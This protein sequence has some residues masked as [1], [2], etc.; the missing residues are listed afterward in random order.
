MEI[1]LKYHNFKIFF[2]KNIKIILSN[3]NLNYKPNPNSLI[4]S[5]IDK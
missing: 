2:L 4:G 1:N 3:L 5:R